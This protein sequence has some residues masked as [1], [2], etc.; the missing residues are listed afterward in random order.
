MKTLVP[1]MLLL[2]ASLSLSAQLSLDTLVILSQRAMT[3]KEAL[4]ALEAQ[5]GYTFSYS[6]RLPLE[7][8]VTFS[9]TTGPLRYFLDH[10]SQALRVRYRVLNGKILF[11]RQRATTGPLLEKVTLSGYLTDAATGEKLIGATVY[12]QERE[13][14]TV[15]NN[16]GYYALPVPPGT[17]TL[18]FSFVG[19][20][21]Q[22]RP[23]LV[24]ESQT[25][26]V[27]LATEEVQLEEVVVSAAG[28]MPS[29]QGAALGTTQVAIQTFRKMPSLLGE[30]DV[31]RS[32]QLLPGV[33]T[34]GEGVSGLNVRGGSTDQNLILLDEAPLF[35]AAH[36][37]G[38]FSVFNP[39]AVQQVTL[40]KG[41][42][43]ARYGGRL[44]SVL[45]VRQKEGNTQRLGFRGGLGL[46]GSRLLLEG[47]IVKDKGSFMLAGRRSYTDL[48][49]GALGGGDFALY[50][51]DLNTKINYQVNDRNR[52]YLS[53]YF[54]RDVFRLEEDWGFGWGNRTGTLRWNHLFNDQLFSN[55]TAIYSDYTYRLDYADLGP[56]AEIEDLVWTSGITHY[57]LQAD[58]TYFLSS[59]STVDF[60]ASAIL[61]R[62]NPGDVSIQATTGPEDISQP[63]AAEQAVEAAVYVNQEKKLSDRVT[64]HF[65]LRYGAFLN[66]GEREVFIYE[67]DDP[68]PGNPMV[69]TLSY[70]AGEIV[71][72]YD[73]LEPRLSFNYSW[74]RQSALKASYHRL[75][76]YIQQ[77]SNT[78]IT[79]PL[80]IWTPANRY[81]RPARVDQVALGY[82]H[83][84]RQNTVAFSTEVYYKRFQDLMD[85]RNG[86]DLL[87]NETLETQLL[88]GPGRAY[89]LEVMLSKEQGRWTGWL[90]YT[91]SRAEQQL[92]GVNNDAYYPTPYD[93]PHDVSLVLNYQFTPKWNV[94]TNFAYTTG[95]PFTLPSGRFSYEGGV[96]PDYTR[97]N[98]GRMPN[99]HRLDVSFNYEPPVKPER[100]WR[101]TWT[102]GVY[103]LYARRN[104]YAVSFREKAGSPGQTEAVQLSFF[105]LIPSVTYNFIF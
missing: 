61:Y 38:I 51:Y 104:P 66:V 10:I 82:S 5:S 25:L 39:D 87:L 33:T 21:S 70:R 13:V 78:T 29:V 73:G 105:G 98:G 94:S 8:G 90:S 55:V 41:D 97:R 36:L 95:R 15:S 68:S 101:N 75:F 58:M 16:Y 47:P 96:V 80:D 26:N 102:L 1:L 7:T 27:A 40:Y 88:R 44:S 74:S 56:D 31:I 43:P 45:D 91:L 53:G 100:R 14:G 85:L 11:V 18:L 2:S 28:T 89:G 103:N 86:A 57:H 30:V 77:V 46:I 17:Y 84:F 60:G 19:Y 24:E 22:R 63:M 48:L 59:G 99:Y 12:V 69:D 42:I 76:Q 83:H 79:T 64:L 62:F 3:L 20:Q 32:L 65:G 23:V 9:Q 50:F 67:N 72:S 6:N 4:E 37:G 81:T 71:Q 52:L 35:N 54:G 93:K 34:A 92:D 49:L